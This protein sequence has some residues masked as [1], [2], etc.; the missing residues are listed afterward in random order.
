MTYVKDERLKCDN[1]T[2]DV[3]LKKLPKGIDPL[4]INHYCKPIQP[5]NGSQKPS[6]TKQAINFTKAATVHIVK[7]KKPCPEPLHK[8]RL[9]VCNL[10]R[11]GDNN[12]CFLCGCNIPTKASWKSSSC[13][14]MKWP[15]NMSDLIFTG[16][17]KPANL[18]NKFYKAG[19]FFIGSGPSLE[20]L[21]TKLLKER[22]ILSFGANNIAAY[23]DIRP[24]FWVSCDGVS[25]FHKVIWKDPG[26]MKFVKR[27]NHEKI[28]TPPNT[29]YF[30]VNED[31][32]PQTF[33]TEP[34]VNFGNKS[35]LVDEFG[36]K[37]RRSVMHCALRIMFYLGIRRIYLIGCDFK[38]D[39]KRPYVFDQKKWSGGC[40]TNNKGYEIMNQRFKALDKES[41]KHGLKIYN[42]TPGSQLTAFEKLNYEDAIQNEILET[43][44]SL[45]NMYGDTKNG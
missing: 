16:K 20:T 29:Y 32:M 25:S 2:L 33:F 39:E 45:A 24:N 36:G 44:D 11:H 1:C 38:M 3:P 27:S 41:Q 4:K 21:N 13:P 18:E 15:R 9:E 17:D 19:C 10:C 34:T 37:G 8:I 12:E 43:P 5:Y 23:R 35:D 40:N 42:C 7:G 6:L 26:I 31:F 22:G 14:V 28:D 30:D